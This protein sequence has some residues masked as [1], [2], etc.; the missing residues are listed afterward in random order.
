MSQYPVQLYDGHNFDSG[1]R[2]V[3]L[4]YGDYP[5]IWTTGMPNDWADSVKVAPFTKLILYDNANFGPGDSAT[6]LGPEDV[7]DL[8]LSYRIHSR[9]SSAKVIPM[10]PTLQTQVECCQG[11][12]PAFKCG[13][14]I[15]GSVVCGNS[16]EDYCSTHLGDP[17]CQAWCKQNTERCDPYAQAY[18]N[19]NPGDPFCACIK[20]P[21]QVKGLLNPKCIDSKCLQTGYQTTSMKNTNCPSMVDCSISTTLAN[22]GVIFANTTKI[23]QNC[24]QGNSEP[25]VY[26]VP[27]LVPTPNPVSGGPSDQD[28]MLIVMLFIFLIFI[29]LSLVGFL[30]LSD[31]PIDEV[32]P[33]VN[34]AI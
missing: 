16:I 24:G 12:T 20:S 8:G 28:I 13:K 21:A 26:T 25:V 2:M 11:I 33:T 32:M 3:N 17:K 7:N 19:T 23:E 10:P 18:C 34:S 9:T 6:I 31:D 29:S 1:R 22:S 4:D 5:Q 30:L 27:P 15:P 14:Y